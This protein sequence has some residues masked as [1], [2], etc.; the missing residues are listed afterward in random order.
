[1]EEKKLGFSEKLF[2]SY[3]D[4]ARPVKDIAGACYLNVVVVVNAVFAR[5]QFC[6]LWM[7]S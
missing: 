4:T 7:G 1:M 6:C 3:P 2:L 5:A